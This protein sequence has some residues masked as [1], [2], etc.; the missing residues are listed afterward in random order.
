LNDFSDQYLQ[1]FLYPAVI[2]SVLVNI[3]YA[4]ESKFHSFAFEYYVLLLASCLFPFLP[5]FI[6]TYKY[7]YIWKGQKMYIHIH[8]YMYIWI[9]ICMFAYLYMSLRLFFQKWIKVSHC[10][11]FWINHTAYRQFRIVF[12]IDLFSRFIFLFMFPNASCF[13]I[14]FIWS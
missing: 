8:S 2:W 13:K 1:D 4:I 9:H 7:M 14:S 3:S 6:N 12:M 10:D 11:Y 5:P